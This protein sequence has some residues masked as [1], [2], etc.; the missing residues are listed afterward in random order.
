MKSAPLETFL[1]TVSPSVPSAAAPAAESL[2]PGES[3]RGVIL[4]IL[5][6][7]AP[8]TGDQ[9]LPRSELGDE[10]YQRSLRELLERQYIQQDNAGYALTPAGLDAAEKQRARLLSFW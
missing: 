10:L 3:A 5:A 6:K 8:L 9:L 7:E 2:D 1:T 4:T